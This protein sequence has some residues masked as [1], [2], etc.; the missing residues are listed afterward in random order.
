ME[1][2]TRVLQ[3]YNCRR[4]KS[5]CSKCHVRMAANIELKV[6]NWNIFKWKTKMPHCLDISSRWTGHDLTILLT[7][8]SEDGLV[9]KKDHQ[10]WYQL[11]KASLRHQL[12]TQSADRDLWPLLR[13]LQYF[14]FTVVD[15][16]LNKTG[17]FTIQGRALG[18]SCYSDTVA[19]SGTSRYCGVMRAD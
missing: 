15:Q 1:V 18:P 16:P 6:W 3:W 9:E 10:Y 14:I 13:C 12:Q 17:V 11:S 4:K 5:S 8:G 19:P 2:C 7:H